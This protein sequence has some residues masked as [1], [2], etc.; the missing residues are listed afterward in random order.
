MEKGLFGQA[1]IAWRQQKKENVFTILDFLPDP[2]L[3]KTSPK[4]GCAIASCSTRHQPGQ[5]PFHLNIS[6][7]GFKQP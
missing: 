6:M 7:I 1:S 4:A 2:A 3:F 5:C